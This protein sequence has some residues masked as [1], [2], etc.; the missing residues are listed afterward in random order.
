MATRWQVVLG[1]TA[2]GVAAAPPIVY[3]SQH[4]IQFRNLRLV[5][6][7]VLYR[8]GQLTP[9]GLERVLHEKGIKTVVTLRTS[10][11]VGKLPPDTWE[12]DVCASHGLKHVRIIPR[13]WSPDETGDVP[14]EDAVR[15]FLAVM[16]D[17]SNYPVLVHC[18]A[19][20]H[21]TGTMCAIF[22]MEYDRWPNERAIEEMRRCGF[23]PLDMQEFIANYLRAYQPRWK[24]TGG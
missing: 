2:A 8:S 7:G 3:T 13:V 10:R 18:F 4:G 22:R 17:K 6:E 23:D 16:D 9:E 19:G 20:I 14:A 5:E 1:L 11:I 12:Q 24:R 15:E 21:R